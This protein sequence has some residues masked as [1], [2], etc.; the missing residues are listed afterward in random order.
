LVT[1]PF[2]C[3]FFQKIPVGSGY[4]K[5]NLYVKRWIGN[6]TLQKDGKKNFYFFV[7][8]KNLFFTLNFFGYW[9]TKKR[10]HSVLIY[11]L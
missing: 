5:T 1:G 9:K 8:K 2:F 6:R 10:E 3:D 7:A 11:F 4:Q